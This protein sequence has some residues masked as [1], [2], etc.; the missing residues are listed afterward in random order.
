MSQDSLAKL[1]DLYPPAHNR[2]NIQQVLLD[3]YGVSL[4]AAL[5]KNG[6]AVTE[7]SDANNGGNNQTVN[8]A[9]GGR[10]LNYVVDMIDKG[11]Y[12]L[13]LSVDGKMINR[14]YANSAKPS[15]L[16]AWTVS[17]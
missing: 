8:N 2:L 5:R 7:F 13:S 14:A 4:A 6:Y 1:V 10:D 3:S 15:V 12:R 16:G 9:G 17:E 11:I